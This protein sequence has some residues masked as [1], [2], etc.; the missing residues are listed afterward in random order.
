MDES[1]TFTE[2]DLVAGLSKDLEHSKQA[3]TRP[4]KQSP[5]ERGLPNSDTRALKCQP[6]NHAR[7]KTRPL[8]NLDSIPPHKLNE[9]R[10][11]SNRREK[12]TAQWQTIWVLLF[13]ES[14]TTPR[15]FLDGFLKE[16]T[17]LIRDIWSQDGKKIVSKYLQG[18]G[19]PVGP[20]QL[21]SLLPKL[22]D[23]V[24][25]RFETKSLEH[26]ID[27]QCPESHELLKEAAIGE[28]ENPQQGAVALDHVCHHF[29]QTSAPQ[30]GAGKYMPAWLPFARRSLALSA[31]NKV[32]MF[33]RP[34]LYHA[35]QVPALTKARKSCVAAAK[36]IFK[37]YESISE[38]GVIPIWT[39]SAFCV[40]AIIV[41][42]LKLLFRE[43]HTDDEASSSHSIM[44]RTAQS[45]KSKQSDIIA[46][47]CAALIKT[48]L[49]VEQ[50]LVVS[51]MRSSIEGSTTQIRSVQIKMANRMVGGNEIMAKFLAYRPSNVDFGSMPSEPWYTDNNFVMDLLQNDQFLSNMSENEF[52]YPSNGDIAFMYTTCIVSE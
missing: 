45:L 43:T 14:D 15:P 2:D 46:A 21:F 4:P 44:N 6:S 8:N 28:A 37:E 13:G 23:T 33:H 39:H 50:E 9:L 25:E 30:S 24:E 48:I 52:G 36:T 32:I 26:E 34:V 17:G 27:E 16:F 19:M 5:K 49:Q 11:R 10:L 18:R 1:I 51:L 31:A 40:T 29:M 42:G 22:L 47:P 7:R 3:H 20:D 38:E 35:F 12:P 41:I